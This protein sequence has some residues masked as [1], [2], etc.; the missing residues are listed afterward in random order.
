MPQV[1]Q[2]LAGLHARVIQ[3]L[4]VC[5]AGTSHH[6]SPGGCSIILG[7]FTHPCHPEVLLLA[8][9]PWRIIH[10]SVCLIRDISGIRDFSIRHLI[11]HF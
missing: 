10:I 9:G 8:T 2:D 7:K 6:Q 3:D 5:K 4:L 11:R 1:S